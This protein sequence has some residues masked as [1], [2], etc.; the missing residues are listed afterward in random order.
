MRIAGPYRPVDKRSAIRLRCGGGAMV[1]EASLIHPTAFG[2][3]Q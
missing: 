3:A 1:D 2:S